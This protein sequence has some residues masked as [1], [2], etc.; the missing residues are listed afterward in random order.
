M[1]KIYQK[2]ELFFTI[3][4]II[5]Y[6]VLMSV[7]DAL[8]SIIG[9]DKVITAP[10]SIIMALFLVIWIKNNGLSS[11]YGLVGAE[12]NQKTFLCFIPLCLMISVNFWGG[13]N[14]NFNLFEGILFI[15][16]MI[17]VGVIEEIIFRGFLFKVLQKDNLTVAII[18]TSLTFGI[19]H[20][21][22]LL[23]GA[24]LVSTLLQIVYASSAGFLFTVIF[25]KTGSLFL[26]IA[27]HS[28]VNATSLFHISDFTLDIVT[29]IVLT[30]TSIAY[31]FWILRCE[32]NKQN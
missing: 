31:A 12:Y 16:S 24:E 17:A 15:I 9:I 27:I 22:N 29:A 26:C 14:L 8:S 4:W 10:L 19:G 23:N 6:V 5:A 13:I 25:Y 7:A 30:V 18:V 1:K 3:I 11:K 28:I 20:I 32:K 21:V 2:S